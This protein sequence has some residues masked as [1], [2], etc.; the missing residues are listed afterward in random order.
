MQKQYFSKTTL[1][2]TAKLQN[3]IKKMHLRNKFYKETAGLSV[4][5]LT[6]SSAPEKIPVPNTLSLPQ[7]ISN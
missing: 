6:P 1:N 2:T 7:Y 5:P 4:P 3:C